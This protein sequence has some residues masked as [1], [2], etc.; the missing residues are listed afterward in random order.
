[1][2]SLVLRS[3]LMSRARSRANVESSTF[4]SDAEVQE[5]IE[6]GIDEFYDLILEHMGAD[7]FVTGPVTITAV[8]NQSLYT[9]P[10]DFYRVT[11]I[12]ENS[13][14]QWRAMKSFNWVDTARLQNFQGGF[15][16]YRYRVMGKQWDG[17]VDPSVSIMVLPVPQG[18]FSFQLYYVP[19][20]QHISLGG[21]PVKYD[22]MNGWTE[23][24]VLT[25][26]IKMLTKEES[27]A[28]ALEAE[29]AQIRDRIVALAA[30]R[31]M[32]SG[33]SIPDTRRG[34]RGAWPYDGADWDDD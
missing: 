33:N 34:R 9:L 27:D 25:A 30:G 8:A 14:S 19:A 18:P 15:P 32:F 21:G 22:S 31:D 16:V 4:V 28:S 23:W 24:A 10:V 5:L 20:I 13:R 7:T 3:D 11:M 1:M 12:E 17:A 29:R 2:P 6:N 26:A